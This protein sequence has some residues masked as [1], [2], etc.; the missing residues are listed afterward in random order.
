MVVVITTK[1]D[2]IATIG[3][4]TLSVETNIIQYSGASF[5]YIVEGYVDLSAMQSGDS[6]TITEYIAVDESNLRVYKKNV[7]GG[8]QA[9]PILR[10]HSKTLPAAVFYRATINQTTGTG[11]S[12]PMAF[13]QEIFNV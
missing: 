12:Y 13:I 6:V 1:N 4:V 8:V 9:E 10:F 11:R 7:F 2:T 3:P 5:D